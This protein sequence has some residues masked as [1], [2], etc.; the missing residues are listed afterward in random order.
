MHLDELTRAEFKDKVSQ[1]TVVI[2]PVGAVEEHGDH[3]PLGADTIQPKFVAEEVARRAGA[4]LAPP[5]EYGHCTTTRNF[6]GTI[7]LSFETMRD[8]LHDVLSELA[9]NGVRNIVV[10][11]GHAGSA[12]MA[13][14]RLAAKDV[15]DNQDVKIAVVSDYEILYREKKAR[16]G[17]GHSG[18][19]E[20]SRMLAIRP[21]LVKD[22][23][24]G[25]KNLI[26]E[27]VVLRHPERYWPEGVT[28]DPSEA[29]VESG[30]EYNEFVIEK[31]VSLVKSLKEM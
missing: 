16:E 5:I 11:S 20:T 23:R 24:K 14:L 17:D 10:L 27:Y 7:S 4:L 29:R 12:H 9:R 13:A 21:D 25:G 26:P 1:D 22:S 6:P 8:L 15:V 3:L 18:F 19:L 28:G 31:L 30:K 2:L